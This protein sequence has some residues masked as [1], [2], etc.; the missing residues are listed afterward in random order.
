V[1]RRL[2]APGARFGGAPGTL[3][4]QNAM[5]NPSRTAATASAL[6]IGLALVTV[7][8]VLAAGLKT[9]FES[10]V[11]ALFVADY[12]L[13]SQNGFIPT[14]TE[15]A[16]AL[17][18]VPGVETVSA[19]RAG[20]GRALGHHVNITAVD[21][22]GTEVISLKWTEGWAATPGQLGANGAIVAKQ[23][24]KD[25]HL[26]VGSPIDL[27]VPTGKTLHPTLKG[28]FDPPKGGSPFGDLTIATT[29]FDRN[30]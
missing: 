28:I 2:G 4:R 30:Y 6:M 23:Y 24:A 11:N 15:S 18:K 1:A 13:T 17:K 10:S 8:A 9:R 16:E 27:L 14:G 26:Q 29:T 21:P 19:V 3:A 22:Q 20:E 12:A 5:R 25:H 7:V